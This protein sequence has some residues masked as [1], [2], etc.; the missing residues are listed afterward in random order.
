MLIEAA[1]AEVSIFDAVSAM[2][3]A[4]VRHVLDVPHI[5]REKD[6]PS[7]LRTRKGHCGHS[8]KLKASPSQAYDPPRGAA[9]LVGN[10]LAGGP[11]LCGL[12][13]RALGEANVDLGADDPVDPPSWSPALA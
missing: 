6:F 5:K 12:L 1:C 10:Q 9:Y 13:F 2:S 8:G 11:A 7:V 4:R 3:L